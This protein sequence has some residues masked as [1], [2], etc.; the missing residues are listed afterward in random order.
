MGNGCCM[1]LWENLP[2]DRIQEIFT[3]SWLFILTVIFT[4]GI[5]IIQIYKE[6]FLH[7]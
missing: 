6:N 2:I 7:I 1:R 5:F 3:N 4:V